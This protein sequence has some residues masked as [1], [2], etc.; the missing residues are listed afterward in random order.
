MNESAPLDDVEKQIYFLIERR[1]FEQARA[2]A[3]RTLKD[4]PHNTKILLTLAVI[5]NEKNELKNARAILDEILV[6]DSEFHQAKYLLASV[7]KDLKNYIEAE[8]LIIELLGDYPELPGFYVLYSEIMLET[9]HID[10]A[11]RLAD[12]ALRLDPENLSA[13]T[14][15]VIHEIIC[16]NKKEY[17]QKLSELVSLYPKAFATSILIAGVLI[18][19]KKFKEAHRMAMELFKINPHNKELL[20]MIK[21]LRVFTHPGMLI[22]TPS[23][24][25]GWHASVALWFVTIVLTYVFIT[26]VSETAALIWLS[27]CLFY[28]FYSLIFPPI[29]KKVIN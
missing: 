4:D 7:Q 21:Q 20:E 29:L 18:E 2:L 24:K 25:Y 16:A 3:G 23:I 19:R 13:M 22:L 27:I 9:L 5:H 17:T 28:I 11:K 26:F 15:S 10:K 8:R 12:E 1:R 14:I 6:Q